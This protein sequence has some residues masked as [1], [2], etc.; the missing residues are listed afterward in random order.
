M[1]FMKSYSALKNQEH[2]GK[3]VC[4]ASLFGFLAFLSYPCVKQK[5]N[6]TFTKHL[7]AS[8]GERQTTPVDSDD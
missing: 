6:S 3:G 5:K 8:T 2:G 4:A 7:Y 1:N